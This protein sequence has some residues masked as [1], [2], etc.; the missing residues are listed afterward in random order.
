MAGYVPNAE[1]SA[2]VR[3]ML[4]TLYALVPSL[5]NLVGLAIAFFYPISDKVH[6]QIRKAIEDK[7]NGKNVGDPLTK[8]RTAV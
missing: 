4:R 7:S 1:Q 3:F 6:V 2:N 5:L 8:S